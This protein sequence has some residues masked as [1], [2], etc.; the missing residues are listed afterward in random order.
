MNTNYFN[1]PASPWG[2]HH[3][4]VQSSY[5]K[6]A[7]YIFLLLRTKLSNFYPQDKYFYHKLTIEH[8]QTWIMNKD[9]IHLASND[10]RTDTFTSY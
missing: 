1:W 3:Y 6:F 8:M 7:V 9:L 2:V 10:I 5:L 4:L